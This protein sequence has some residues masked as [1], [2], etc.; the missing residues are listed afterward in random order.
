[1]SMKK[2]SICL[3]MGVLFLLGAAAMVSAGDQDFT[4]VNQT[5]VTIMEF[6]CSPTTT[7]E[8]EEDVLGVDTLAPEDSVEIS[9]SR[10]QEECAWDLKIKD[11]DGDEVVWTKINLCKAAVITLYWE[12]GKPTAEI[13]NVEE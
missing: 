8:W 1:M 7:N 3:G 2:L 10:E 11:E 9:F 4:L 13:E 5:G 6:Y 12:D